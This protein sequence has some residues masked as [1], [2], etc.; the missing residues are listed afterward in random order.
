MGRSIAIIGGGII[1]ASTAYYL[2]ALTQQDVEIHI[3]E[4]VSIAAASSGKAGGFLALDWH[5]AKTKSLAALSFKLH[6]ELADA[7]DGTKQW[8]YRRT[9]TL[10]LEIEEKRR[11]KSV[12]GAEWLNSI[13]KA[14]KI[15]DEQTTAQAHPFHLTQTLAKVAQSRGVQIH[16][17]ASAS[18]INFAPDSDKVPIELVATKSDGSEIVIPATDVVFAAGP[19]TGVLA[20][21][22]L[23]KKDAGAAGTIEPS[24]PSSSVVLRPGVSRQITNHMLFT[25]LTF[26]GRSR[27][28]EVYPRSDGTVYLCGAGGEDESIPLP[29]RADQVKPVPAAIQRLKEAAAFVSADTF[30][31]AQ[32]V[33]EQCCFRPNSQTGLPV[34]GKVREGIWMASGH[35]VWGIQ[36][37]PGT[38]KCLAELILGLPTSAD[39]SQ[40]SP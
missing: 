39:I 14:S 29:E 40:L 31:D 32:V 9:N 28:P 12:P 20:R 38:G 3:V 10:Q 16:L 11:N 18:K 27:E 19:W 15:G 36:N 24:E 30:V 23:G 2:S 37:G 6:Q 33:A 21:K 4:S 1:G 25:G 8:G 22:L 35:G 34:I 26:G 17:G 5:G 13:S 7:H